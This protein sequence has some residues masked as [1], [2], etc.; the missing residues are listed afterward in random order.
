M[1]VIVEATVPQLCERLRRPRLSRNQ[2]TDHV[3]GRTIG[4]HVERIG[5]DVVR[6]EVLVDERQR[7]SLV[8]VEVERLK[9]SAD[10]LS[11]TNPVDFM[12][13][14]APSTAFGGDCAGGGSGAGAAVGETVSPPPHEAV[15]SKAAVVTTDSRNI[16]VCPDRTSPHIPSAYNPP[17]TKLSAHFFL[18][19][20]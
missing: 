13:I 4:M 16:S 20:A 3:D 2:E 15:A 14:V 9:K 12:V 1:I 18:R 19:S 17:C 5:H 7:R 6:L 10:A 11:N 8:D